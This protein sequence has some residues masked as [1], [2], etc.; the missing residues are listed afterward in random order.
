MTEQ[1]SG[2]PEGFRRDR[3]E[4]G[5]APEHLDDDWLA[6]ETEAERVAAGL[7]D[8]DPDEVPPA[9]EAPPPETD[10]RETEQYQEERA[11]VRREED[12]GEL[13]VQGQRDPF[14]PTRY[15]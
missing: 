9:T 7:D 12:H 14:P 1:S 4:H 6:S 15:E 3:R 11:E 13:R 5:G 10:V 2:P 8:Y